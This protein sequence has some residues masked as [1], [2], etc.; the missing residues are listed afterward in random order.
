M[1]SLRHPCPVH[2]PRMVIG[3]HGVGVFLGVDER[4]FLRPALI[5]AFKAPFEAA[6]FA[7]GLVIH[8]DED[9]PSPL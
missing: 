1:V 6:L 2:L 8:D 3:G 5:D 9:G 7:D 4:L